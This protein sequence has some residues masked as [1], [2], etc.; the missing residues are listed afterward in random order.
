MGHP[1]S[2]A[3]LS[4]CLSLW[5]GLLFFLSSVGAAWFPPPLGGVAFPISFP[6]GLPSFPSSGWSCFFAFPLLL[7]WRAP[8]AR[9]NIDDLNPNAKQEDQEGRKADPDPKK[10]GQPPKT[11]KEGPPQPSGVVLLFLV[12]IFLI[13]GAVLD[14]LQKKTRQPKF[15]IFLRI[16]K[17][18]RM[19]ISQ[20]KGKRKTWAKWKK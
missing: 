4:V 7:S 20:V 19:F 14:I 11:K 9:K 1:L 18:R 8:N 6:V 16:K 12:S 10:Q 13:H 5:V 15:L 17:K 2:S 3:P